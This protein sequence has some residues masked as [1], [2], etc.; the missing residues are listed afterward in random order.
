MFI[1]KVHDYIADENCKVHYIRRSRPACVSAKGQ[2]FPYGTSKE[3]NCVDIKQWQWQNFETGAKYAPGVNPL[4][5]QRITHNG[6]DT[7]KIVWAYT[8]SIFQGEAYQVFRNFRGINFSRSIF[9]RAK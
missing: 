3:N 5:N 6:D 1:S 4:P 2:C 7:Q 9:P 8:G